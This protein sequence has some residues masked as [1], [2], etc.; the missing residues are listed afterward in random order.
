MARSQRLGKR[1]SGVEVQGISDQGIW[2]LVHGKEY[3]LPYHMYPWF[4]E[5]KVSEIYNVRMASPSHLYWP[6]LDI[7]LEV[8]SLDYPDQYPLVSL[9]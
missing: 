3:F 4:R 1:T 7:D 8:A 6:D 2:C 5:A 9:L